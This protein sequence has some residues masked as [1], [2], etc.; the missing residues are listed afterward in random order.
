MSSCHR[1]YFTPFAELGDGHYFINDPGLV[2]DKPVKLVGDENEP[3]HV[4][5]ELSGKIVWKSPAGWIEGVTIRRPR[6]AIESTP[7]N[8]MLRVESGGRLD[9][10]HCL[11]DNHGSVGNCIS[12]DSHA[13][14]QWEKV[15]ITGGAD[16]HSGLFVK[17]DAKLE[18]VDCNICDNDGIG[19]ASQDGAV[20]KMKSCT[21]ETNNLASK[22]KEELMLIPSSPDDMIASH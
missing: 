22:M 6:I 12:V 2:V 16:G 15:R 1:F 4:I 18:L 5:L 8:D 7:N 17:K 13:G 20:V 3:S 14:G 9:M 21:I 11:F 19:F 10:F